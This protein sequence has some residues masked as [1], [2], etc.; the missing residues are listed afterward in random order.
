MI[1]KVEREDFDDVVRL[2]TQLWPEMQLN[3]DDLKYVFNE[4]LENRNCEMWCYGEKEIAA[5]VTLTKRP[6]F[7]YGGQVAILEDI[8]VD[9]Q[10]RGRN[11]GYELVRFVEKRLENEGIYG[12]EISTA[13]H[14][15]NAHSFYE[16]LGYKRSG[17]HFRKR[18]NME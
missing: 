10:H 17:F 11:I 15:N 8:I 5:V 13:F 12:I 4:Y 9:Q 6:S 18:P 2:F 16:K 14:R 7:Y 1:R 3:Y